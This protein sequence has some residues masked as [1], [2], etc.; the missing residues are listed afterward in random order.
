VVVQPTKVARAD[1][2]YLAIRQVTSV[3]SKFSDCDH[4]TGSVSVPQIT[5]PTT[6]AKKYAIDSHVLGC[7]VAGGT[8][9]CTSDQ[10]AFVDA[11]QPIFV[12]SASTFT[13]VRMPA[14]ASCADVRATLP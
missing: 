5:D 10:T 13:S 12:P 2:L 11:N 1:R 9:D 14:G 8:T 6:F 3:T 4:A 7:R